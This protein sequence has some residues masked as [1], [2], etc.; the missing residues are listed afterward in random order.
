MIIESERISQLV[1]IAFENYEYAKRAK[2]NLNHQSVFRNTVAP[3]PGEEGD[4][5]RTSSRSSRQIMAR[6]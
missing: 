6:S 5:E 1:V 2:A 3:D 4:P